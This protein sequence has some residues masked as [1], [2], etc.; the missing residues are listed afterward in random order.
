ML[1]VTA[2]KVQREDEV[3]VLVA[4]QRISDEDDGHIRGKTHAG[5]YASEAQCGARG[6]L[7]RW[8]CLLQAP[9]WL[10]ARAAA[11][12]K[13]LKSVSNGR[14]HRRIWRRSRCFETLGT[15]RGTAGRE[16][17]CNEP[18]ERGLVAM[19]DPT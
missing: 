18:F 17:A 19:Y 14:A 13:F 10:S 1:K 7:G 6:L 5:L 12:G 15:C 8:Q 3:E 4:R 9:P 2:A 16:Q 11:A